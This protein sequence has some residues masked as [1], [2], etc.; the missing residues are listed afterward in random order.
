VSIQLWEALEHSRFERGVSNLN[1]ALFLYVLEL[2]I[3]DRIRSA[4]T[5]A[6]QNYVQ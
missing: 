5:D 4:P 3:A 6:P 2:G 1:D